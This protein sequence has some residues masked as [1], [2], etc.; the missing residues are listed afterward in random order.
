MI[1]TISGLQ[2]HGCHHGIPK[3]P[4]R[5]F[6]QIYDISLQD[7]PGKPPPSFK[8]HRK[9]KNPYILRYGERWVEKL[10]SSTEM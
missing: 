5:G 1:H 8:D 3:V 2:L 6:G 4:I 9:A 7:L 10:K